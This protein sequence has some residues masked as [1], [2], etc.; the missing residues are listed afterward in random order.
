MYDLL[1]DAWLKEKE[2]VELQILQKDFYTKLTEYIITIQKETR[3]LDRNS[4]KSRLLSQELSRVKHLIQE[5]IELRFEKLIKLSGSSETPKW[6][7]S[8]NE[9][10]ILRKLIGSFE[11]FQSFIKKVLQGKKQN[12]DSNNIPTGSSL[13]RFLKKLPEVV[14]SDLKVYGPFS[15]EDVAALPIEN[16]KVLTKHGAAT[17]IEVA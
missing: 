15:V 3:M 7:L 5:L 14:G 16:A 17:I 8:T 12:V 10:E 4:P 11:N 9:R 13:M 6:D 2:Y 1:Y